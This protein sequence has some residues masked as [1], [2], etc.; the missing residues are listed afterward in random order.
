MNIKLTK[1]GHYLMALL[2]LL[3]LNTLMHQ[4]VLQVQIKFVLGTILGFLFL[5]VI[6]MWIGF[7]LNKKD[8]PKE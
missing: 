4:L 2:V 7:V 3:L 1:H 5:I 8:A 6:I